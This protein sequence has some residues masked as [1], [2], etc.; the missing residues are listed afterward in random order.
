[1]A[2]DKANE[3]NLNAD[4]DKR[5]VCGVSIEEMSQCYIARKIY[6]RTSITLIKEFDKRSC[7]GRNN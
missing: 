3:S 2:A 5:E 1:M 6:Q 4:A 7:R